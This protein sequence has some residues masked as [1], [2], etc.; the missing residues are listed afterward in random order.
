MAARPPDARL[1]DET[2]LAFLPKIPANAYKNIFGH[3]LVIGGTPQYSGA[4]NLAARAALRAGA[5]LVSVAAPAGA[6]RDIK[7]G[8]PEIMTLPLGKPANSTWPK[9]IPEALSAAL[10]RCTAL[11]TGPGMGRGPDSAAFLAALLCLPKRPPAVIDADALVIIANQPELRQKLLPRDILTPH[12]GEAAAL[13]RTNAVS[14][15]SDRFTALDW[16]C[17][18]APCAVILKGAG[19]LAGQAPKPV[20]VSPYDVPQLAVGGSGDVLAGCLGALLAARHYPD[21][22]VVAGMGIVLHALAGKTLAAAF[23]ARGNTAGEIAD[24]IPRVLI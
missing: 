3:V 22:L 4:A 2:C 16:L 11:V 8:L 24:A 17:R 10:E 7:N 1:L 12:P 5:G 23:P 13:L 14:I 6:V 18:L 19:T 21:S 15:Q 9:K 20:L